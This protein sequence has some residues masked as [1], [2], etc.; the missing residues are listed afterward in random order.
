VLDFG[1]GNK[2]DFQYFII[3]TID[4]Q[5]PIIA[6]KNYIKYDGYNIPLP[7]N[8]FVIPSHTS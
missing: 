5:K 2:C 4:V 1:G 8:Y 7:D 6:T 3:T